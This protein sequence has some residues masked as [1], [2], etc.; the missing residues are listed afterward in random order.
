MYGK[1]PNGGITEIDSCN[2]DFL[3]DEFL[4]I[5]EIKKDLELYELQQDLQPSLSEG[6]DLNSRQV[7][8]DGKPVQGNE[9]RPHLPTLVENQ[10]KNMKSP[11]AQNP[12]PQRDSDSV[13]PQARVPTPLRER[14]RDSPARQAN[15][16]SPRV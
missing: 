16:E 11:H 6:E 3:E 5:G 4:S 1:H 15:N 8:E 2:V 12:T 9:V 10:P 13:Y 14:E 7:T